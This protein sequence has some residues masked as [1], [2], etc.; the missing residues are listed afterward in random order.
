MERYAWE[1]ARLFMTW[2]MIASRAEPHTDGWIKAVNQASAHQVMAMFFL[3][4]R[5]RRHP[6]IL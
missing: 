4:M 6:C 5:P 3:A 1:H 2:A